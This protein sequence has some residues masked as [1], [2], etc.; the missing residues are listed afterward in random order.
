MKRLLHG[1]LRAALYP[2]GGEACANPIFAA[3]TQAIPPEELLY[4]IKSFLSAES[5]DDSDPYQWEDFVNSSVK[6]GSYKYLVL[7][8]IYLLRVDYAEEAT[9]LNPTGL[10]KLKLLSDAI[11]NNHLPEPCATEKFMLE[12]NFISKRFIL[13]IKQLVEDEPILLDELKTEAHTPLA[14]TGRFNQGR[15]LQIGWVWRGS[16][17]YAKINSVSNIDFLQNKSFCCLS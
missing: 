3:H 10:H 13:Y 16:R 11:E 12:S 6:A 2:S 4:H 15:Y 1:M 14:R 17:A 5:A 7:N 8:L 9:W